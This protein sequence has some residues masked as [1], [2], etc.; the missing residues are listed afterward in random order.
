MAAL[1]QEKK[2]ARSRLFSA[3]ALR[4][5]G[6]ANNSR[7]LPGDRIW[8]FW[9][10][11]QTTA[12][13]HFRQAGS[14][15]GKD[16]NSRS[17]RFD[18][19]Q[20]KP[21][22]TRGMYECKRTLIYRRQIFVVNLAGT[23]NPLRIVLA[24]QFSRRQS[25]KSHLCSPARTSDGDS[26]GKRVAKA[27]TN[28]PTFFFL[29]NPPRKRKYCGGSAYFSRTRAICSALQSLIEAPIGGVVDH[30]DAVRRKTMK[31]ADV[32]FRE[33]GDGDVLVGAVPGDKIRIL[34]PPTS[35]PVLPPAILRQAINNVMAGQ[36][37]LAG[38]PIWE[39]AIRGGVENIDVVC[40]NCFGSSTCSQRISLRA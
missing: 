18:E 16:G 1:C 6:I 30:H 38:P 36:D 25:A 5:A 2:L 20:P 40:R 4:K 7:H 3:R 24:R 10:E 8:I 15:G 19:L 17:H 33:V 11:E 31:P 21:F 28:A 37:V 29:S 34:F 23:E 26:F 12:T 27:S 22:V 14:F 39:P 35:T 13:E 32:L 9:I